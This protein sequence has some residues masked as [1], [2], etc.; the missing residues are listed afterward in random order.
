MTATRLAAATGTAV[1]VVV[2]CALALSS[3]RGT[4]YGGPCPAR[5]FC[6]DAAQ[7]VRAVADGDLGR[8]ADTQP[9]MGPVS[10]FLRGAVVAVA[11]PQAGDDT[12]DYRW[13][14]LA[15]LV[16]AALLAGWIAS[17]APPGR[18]APA[19][20]LLFPLLVVLNPGTV[21]MLDFGHPEEVLC[22][23]LA[24][25]AVV[26]AGTRATLAAA[27]LL[28]V[29]LATKQWALLA[30]GPVLVAAPRAEWARV[31]AIAVAVAVA[32]SLPAALG[33]TERFIDAN[34]DV[35]AD[36]ADLTPG[37]VWWP[38]RVR[39][40]EAELAPGLARYKPPEIA[41]KLAHPFVPV[42]AFAISAFAAFRV[43]RPDLN[44]ALLAVSLIMLLR[45][46]LDPYTFSYH[47]VPFLIALLA[48]E[49]AGR[50][51]VPLVAATGGA[52]LY[53]TSYS[54]SGR[55]DP[56]ALNRF[57]LGWAIPFALLLVWL[58][59]RASTPRERE[60]QPDGQGV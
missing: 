10:V 54:L 35:V 20:A 7:A 18:W 11:Q 33:N 27:V 49:V 22:A 41:K 30:A 13:G 59:V 15:C 40:A 26:A 31:A 48:W 29:A 21:R 12:T 42:L 17:R 58:L 39:F 28:G 51:R 23:V 32:L 60:E 43:R 1:A 4:D 34:A 36:Q 44:T 2:A 14:A 16:A 46:L 50:G 25:A 52:L 8:F 47:H 38:A 55:D 19:A 53:L 5:D 9:T 45:C 57:Y 56:D 24:M 6:N 37:N 3:E